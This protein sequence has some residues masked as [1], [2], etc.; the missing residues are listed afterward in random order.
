MFLYHMEE[1]AVRVCHCFLIFFNC[2]MLRIELHKS[3][4]FGM[5]KDADG[6]H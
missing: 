3:Y 2:T 4:L 5:G 1:L 6:I